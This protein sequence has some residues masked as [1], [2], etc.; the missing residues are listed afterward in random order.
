VE[1]EVLRSQNLQLVSERDNHG[2]KNGRKEK[3]AAE[4]ATAQVAAH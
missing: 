1:I 4:T 2:N 3:A